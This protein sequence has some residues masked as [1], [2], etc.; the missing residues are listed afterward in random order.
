M[1]L[2]SQLNFG[3]VPGDVKLAFVGGAA[4]RIKLTAN[5]RLYKFTEY[6]L[7]GDDDAVTAWWSSVTPLNPDDTG[8]EILLERAA[9]VGVDP[10]T[11]A[12]ARNAVTK[13]WN[14]MGQLRLARL[15]VPVWGFVGTV[16]HQPVEKKPE[17]KK[18]VFI[19]GAVQLWIPNLS[20]TTIG[21]VS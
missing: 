2:N 11:F 15:K 7:F 21:Q 20:S 17:K 14:A 8:L 1:T 5:T 16:R 13:E 12:R 6:P 4:K 3:D 19:G 10:S 18:V 9:R